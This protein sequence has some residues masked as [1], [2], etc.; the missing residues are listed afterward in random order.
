MSGGSGVDDTILA[1]YAVESRQRLA[2]RNESIRDSVRGSFHA[3][4]DVKCRCAWTR[5]APWTQRARPPR[6]G[7][8]H[9]PRFPT[10]PTRTLVFTV[11]DETTAS[12]TE[13]LTLPEGGIRTRQD[14]LDSVSCRFHVADN[15]A[16]AIDPVAPCTLLHAQPSSVPLICT[17][18]PSAGST[19]Q[20]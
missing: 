9:R 8:P 1:L 4:D 12:H 3:T 16:D 5:P 2:P 20:P 7:K 13:F 17:S 15:A 19:K 6:L 14:S 18:E 10:A 11:K